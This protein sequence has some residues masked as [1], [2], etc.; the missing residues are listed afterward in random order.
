MDDAILPLRSVSKQLVKEYLR[1]R[2]M[3]SEVVEWKFYDEDFNRGRE[4]GYVWTRDGVVHGF[5]GLIPWSVCNR[6][7]RLEMVWG[8]DWSVNDPNVSKGMGMAL[9]AHAMSLHR[10]WIS[11]GGSEKAR[12][13]MPHLANRVVDEAG[14]VFWQPLRLGA[15]LKKLGDRHRLAD[16]LGHTFLRSVPIR[17]VR[18]RSS[19][20]HTIHTVPGLSPTVAELIEQDHHSEWHPHHRFD[21]LQWSMGRCPSIA[22]RTSYITGLSGIEAAAVFWRSAQASD[23]WK[24]ALWADPTR[25][26]LLSDLLHEVRWQ[27]YEAGGL[28]IST[29]VSHLET[30]LIDHLQA[31]GYWRQ[32][33]PLPLYLLSQ[34]KQPLPFGDMTGLS[35]V[36]TDLAYRF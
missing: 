17:W 1:C 22:I 5:I 3:P 28:A 14:L 16:W 12:T 19:R 6:G 21:D 35:Y 23:F 25:R 18:P 31:A 26:Q 29:L 2:G 15:A 4:R 11:L 34:R 8:C 30:D 20:S 13:I 36:C 24:V 27:V 7:E 32:P 9:A 33:R 10:P